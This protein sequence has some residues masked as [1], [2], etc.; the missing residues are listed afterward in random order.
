MIPEIVFP[1]F[2]LVVGTLVI[3]FRKELAR[4]QIERAKRNKGFLAKDIAKE[5]ETK[6]QQYAL[7]AGTGFILLALASI[8]FGF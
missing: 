8:V 6:M 4:N 2:G 1:I 7:I 3:V 5:P